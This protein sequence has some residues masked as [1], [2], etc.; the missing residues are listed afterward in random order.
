MDPVRQFEAWLEEAGK[1]EVND[2]NACALATVE[3]GADGRPR[4]DVRM[5][6][7]K[8]VDGHG[9]V[10]FTNYNSAKGRQLREVPFAALDFHWKTL[11]RQ[12][13]VQGPAAPV[14]AGESDD[15]FATRQRASQLSAWASLQSAPL[16]DRAT[17]EA[18]L[19]EMD[20]RFPDVVPRPPHWG[21]FRLVPEWIELWQDRPGRQ[22][23]RRRFT[24]MGDGWESTLLY[25]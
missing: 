9:F 21:G 23:Q 8:E 12:V 24:R 16:D 5:V 25:P 17:F 22:H 19:A 2:P 11:R 13:R 1:T 15:Y 20:R 10:F 6:L 3:M 7:L 18:R 4:P 14:A